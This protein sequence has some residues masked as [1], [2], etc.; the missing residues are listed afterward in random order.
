MEE[1]PGKKEEF[2]PEL[3]VDLTPSEMTRKE[4]IAKIAMAGG[5]IAGSTSLAILTGCGGGGN[6]TTGGSEAQIAAAIANWNGTFGTNVR[7]TNSVDEGEIVDNARL[8]AVV[9]E[10]TD[11]TKAYFPSGDISNPSSFTALRITDDPTIT[12]QQIADF[13]AQVAGLVKLGHR[14]RRI[15]W[16]KG[17]TT[18]TTLTVH[19]G[20][21]IV[22]DTM[23]SN[24]V[25]FPSRASRALCFDG[26]LQWVWGG[27]RGK[28]VASVSAVCKSDGTLLTCTHSC[29]AWMTLGNAYIN[30]A[31]ST[32]GN[33]CKMDWSYGWACGFKTVKLKADK[34]SFEI[35]GIIGSGGTGSESCLDCCPTGS[36]GGTG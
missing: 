29:N 17:G 33:C 13:Q 27:V 23:F 31:T 19:N 26:T 28:I 20:T 6:N 16:T 4:F 24:M 32:V 34:F 5:L 12:P 15:T 3:P 7:A 30:C 22:Y 25:L 21:D 8:A 1:G 9:A 2:V 14:V 35:E 36:A 18:F 10:M 11:P